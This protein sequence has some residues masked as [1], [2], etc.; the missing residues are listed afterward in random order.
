M[1]ISCALRHMA[2]Q[3]GYLDLRLE[4]VLQEAA[5]ILTSDQFDKT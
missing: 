4:V 2:R 5:V 3:L 1:M